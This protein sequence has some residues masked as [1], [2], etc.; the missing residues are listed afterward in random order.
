MFVGGAFHTTMSG[1]EI[2]EHSLRH[3]MLTFA[4]VGFTPIKLHAKKGAARPTTH[5]WIAL[6]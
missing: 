5:T 3:N 1:V 4:F 2:L 6:P